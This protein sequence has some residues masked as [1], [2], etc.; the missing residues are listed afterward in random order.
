MHPCTQH[1]HG[2]PE[3]QRLK[4]LQSESDPRASSSDGTRRQK[5]QDLLPARGT[6]AQQC[7]LLPIIIQ[8]LVWNCLVLNKALQL[9][10]SRKCRIIL[11]KCKMNSLARC[12]L[13]FE[14]ISFWMFRKLL[15]LADELHLLPN[16]CPL[17]G[18]NE[19]YFCY[20]PTG[21]ASVLHISF[22]N[23]SI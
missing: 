14:R 13:N 5:P 21:L 4:C 11:T 12:C 19:V 8:N 20:K 10:P 7:V 6:T 15:S 17:R 2:I 1:F 18:K 22:L 23:G 9:Q 16:V 3:K